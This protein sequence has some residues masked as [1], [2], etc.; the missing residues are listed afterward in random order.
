MGAIRFSGQSYERE[1]DGGWEQREREREGETM[2]EDRR[3]PARRHGAVLVTDLS[4]KIACAKTPT[5]FGHV[6]ITCCNAATASEIVKGRGCRFERV[7]GSAR[8]R[9][10]FLRKEK[11][12]CRFDV[13]R[14]N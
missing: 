2:R 10:A 5:I 11:V 8:S 1:K 9:L 3:E 12:S 4:I 14:K 7:H 6:I 13:V